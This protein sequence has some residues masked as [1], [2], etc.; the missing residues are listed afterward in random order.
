MVR[1]ARHLRQTVLLL[2]S[3]R[4]PPLPT[5]PLLR[6]RR[7]QLPVQG[8]RALC[9]LVARLLLRVVVALAGVLA[10][11][12]HLTTLAREVLMSLLAVTRVMAPATTEIVVDASLPPVT[13]PM[14]VG[15]A[16]ALAVAAQVVQVAL[17]A[18]MGAEA[19]FPGNGTISIG[20]CS[21]QKRW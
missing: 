8:P 6:R 4:R 10:Q 14:A 1:I 18:P 5:L 19:R 2:R 12:P 20:S 15:A 9:M 11:R 3:L 16:E 13:L 7:C 17:G 21:R